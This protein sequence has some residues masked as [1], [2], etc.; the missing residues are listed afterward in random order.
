M[1]VSSAARTAPAVVSTTGVPPTTTAMA[2]LD[3]APALALTLIVAWV[4]ASRLGVDAPVATAGGA[5]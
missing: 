3:E 2:V 4:T 5:W 1:T